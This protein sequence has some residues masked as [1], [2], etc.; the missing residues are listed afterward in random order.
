[1]IGS[2]IF[3]TPGPIADLVPH[4]GLIL[5]AWAFGGLLSLAGALATDEE[6]GDAPRFLSPE[7]ISRITHQLEQK[8]RDVVP[9]SDDNL[10]NNNSFH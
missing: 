4:A 6:G 10:E 3:L 2:G 7:M 9:L 1:M 8:C 5:L